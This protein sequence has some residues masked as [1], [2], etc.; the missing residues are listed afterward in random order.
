MLKC[1]I[2]FFI[3]FSE[4]V[5]IYTRGGDFDTGGGVEG[6]VGVHTRGEIYLQKKTPGV[7]DLL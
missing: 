2:R 3:K 1:Q 6:G 4:G 5:Y 7:R